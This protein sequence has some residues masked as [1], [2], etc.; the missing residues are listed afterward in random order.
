MRNAT[1][2]FS[3]SA[4]QLVLLA[5]VVIA[6][7]AFSAYSAFGHR[8]PDW[9]NAYIAAYSFSRQHP[10][11][12][13][14]AQG[15]WEEFRVGLAEQL[16]VVPAG[17]SWR[18]PPLQA[19]LMI[20][21]L[22]FEMWAACSIWNILGSVASLTASFL[23]AA[24]LTNDSTL[25]IANRCIALMALLFFVPL[26]NTLWECQFNLLPLLSVATGMYFLRHGREASAGVALAVG[27]AMKLFPAS[28][29]AWLLWRRQFRTGVA[30]VLA[31]IVFTLLSGFIVG[32][33]NI[34]G[35]VQYGLRLANEGWAIQPPNQSLF[36]FFARAF[37]VHPWGP[38]LVT[39][40]ELVEPLTWATRLVLLGGVAVL[41]WPRRFSF[42]LLALECSLVL[43][44][45]FLIAPTAWEHHLVMLYVP[46]VVLGT[47]A[48][49]GRLS[50]SACIL[51]IGA[52]ILIDMQGLLWKQFVGYTSLLSLGT[53][54]ML[55]LWAVLAWFILREKWPGL[56]R[57]AVQTTH[58]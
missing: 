48:L 42:D 37:T 26:Y 15:R 6:A 31:S 18:Y 56:A 9:N 45:L 22:P 3:T 12:A 54:A 17:G 57:Q 36:A 28:L 16:R 4:V 53:Y 58:T 50:L 19:V 25:V 55:I 52:Y 11:Y 14:T 20:P 46:F 24:A 21:L 29:I 43:V 10:V 30:A 1:R 51:T 13:I 23:L 33:D 40:P 7:F 27:T 8:P 47:R 35:Y 39:S 49:S 2:R 44:T 5:L 38:T 41:C 32:W 34:A